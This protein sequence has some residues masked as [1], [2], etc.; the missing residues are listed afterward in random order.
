MPYDRVSAGER[1]PGYYLKT[2]AEDLG[3]PAIFLLR[4]WIIRRF[5]NGM[6][7]D[8]NAPTE[9]ALPEMRG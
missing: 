8:A 3:D 6:G 1:L 4:G 2:H 5:S 7:R 9:I